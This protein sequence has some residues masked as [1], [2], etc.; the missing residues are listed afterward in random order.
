[1]GYLK[2]LRE[3]WKKPSTEV[4]ALQRER[5]IEMRREPTTLRLERPT[6]LDRARSLGYRSMKGILI[7]R[8]R[9]SR[10]GRKRP[11][12]RGGRRTAHM[13]RNKVVDKNYQRVCEERVSKQ[14]TNCEV[15]NSYYLAKDGNHIW[16]EVILI[17]IDHPN[18]IKHTGLRN[19][20]R[21]RGR[22]FRGLTSAGR[23]SRGLRNKGKGAEKLRPSM[24]ANYNRKARKK[25]TQ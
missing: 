18:I 8:Q 15:L 19:L 10:G 16:Y 9:V 5:L 17:E 25:N 11:Q 21:K 14:Y 7:V 12:L 13:G 24:Q 1:M 22:T 6:R 2:Y 23:K 20:A 4:K 3:A